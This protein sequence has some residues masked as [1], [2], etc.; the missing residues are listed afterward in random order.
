MRVALYARVSKR[1]DQNPEN[2]LLQLRRWAEVQDIDVVGE[3]VDERTTRDQRPN[4]ETVLKMLRTGELDGVAFTNLDRW[5][6]TMTELVM[7]MEE[8]AES[9][10]ALISI[11]EGLDMGTASGRLAAHVL[12]AMANF[13]RERIRERT[14]HGIAR[15]RAQ[16][17]RIGR[18][19]KKKKRK[20]KEHDDR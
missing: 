15:A 2:Q 8:F 14:L 9:G 20:T 17:K 3:F 19:P 18:P 11:N 7:E 6:R 10:K 12:A 5:G 13:E 4:K 1:L 16:G